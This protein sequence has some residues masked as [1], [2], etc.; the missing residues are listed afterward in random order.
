MNGY[1]FGLNIFWW[2][3]EILGKTWLIVWLCWRIKLILS[4]KYVS[5]GTYEGSPRTT[6]SDV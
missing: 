1:Y 3:H 5:L 2:M 6:R 4:K